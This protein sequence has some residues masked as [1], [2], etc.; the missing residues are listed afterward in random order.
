MSNDTIETKTCTKCKETFPATLEYFH[1]HKRKKYGLSSW[2]KICQC[3]Y[4]REY[5]QANK[6]KIAENYHEYYQKNQDKLR[7]YQREYRIENPDKKRD[8]DRAYA[9]MNQDKIRQY[10]R[11]YRKTNQDAIRGYMRE[12]QIEYRKNNP[13]K[14]RIRVL[15]RRARVRSLFDTFTESQWHDCLEYFGYACAVCGISFEDIPVHADHWIPLSS[16]ECTGTIVTNMVCL[17][18]MCNLSKHDKMPDTWLRE[19]HGIDK[20]NEILKQV[21]TYF[22]LVKI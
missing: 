13:D 1:A 14:S 18:S 6:A 22:E 15:R 20:A 8:Y 4:D 3:N 19:K 11:E 7:K 5:K 16:D 21:N 9:Q 17:C 12:Y 2:C 10:K